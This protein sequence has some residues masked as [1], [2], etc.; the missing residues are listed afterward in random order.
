MLLAK[1]FPPSTHGKCCPHLARRK[2]VLAM[3]QDLSMFVASRTVGSKH[4]NDRS[5]G[6]AAVA[7][8]CRTDPSRYPWLFDQFLRGT[9]DKPGTSPAPFDSKHSGRPFE[10]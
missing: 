1:T 2:D 5:D 10:T 7:N 9:S 6:L 4:G 8:G 3:S